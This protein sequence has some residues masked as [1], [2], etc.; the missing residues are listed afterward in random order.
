MTQMILFLVLACLPQDDATIRD[1]I[2]ALDDDS[3]Q[4]RDKAFAALVGAGAAAEPEL[5]K[6]AR[7]GGPEM[8]ARAA[9]AL[10]A[11]GWKRRYDP[12]PS[13]IT[14]HREKAPLQEVL[15]ELAKQSATE[16]KFDDLEKATR[17]GPVTVHLDKVP[18]YRA[19][20]AICRS[21]GQVD[22]EPSWR[23]A[24]MAVGFSEEPFASCPR[25]V[26]GAIEFRLESVISAVTLDRRGGREEK[27]ELKFLWCAEKG[28]RPLG[29]RVEI[30][31]LRD[32][33]GTSYVDRLTPGE[34][35]LSSDSPD[36]NVNRELPCVPPE[37]V[38]RLKIIKGTFVLVFPLTVH[39]FL[40]EPPAGNVGATR[41][42]RWGNVTLASFDAGDDSFHL[43][44]EMRPEELRG[45]ITLSLLDPKGK[46]FEGRGAGIGDMGD[47]AFVEQ[48]Y[49]RPEG[50]SAA[51]LRCT[52]EVGRR[53]RRIP[54]E[55][56]DV[57]I[58]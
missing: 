27:T 46:E 53:E 16:V 26:D 19:L 5:Q 51:V 6:A 35:R 15:A 44:V 8:R 38:T 14:I 31:E 17:E 30:E 43:K 18:L 3:A 4:V 45:R 41:A 57:R 22:Y 47:Y 28:T 52:A 13:Q 20:E 48:D 11:L 1:W 21:H 58:R 7:N 2:R 25:V 42:S 54:F 32:D 36:P 12:G 9:D 29:G 10:R 40:F 34:E 39:E 37:G 33:A 49:T 55:F 24:D 23:A 56:R 50:R